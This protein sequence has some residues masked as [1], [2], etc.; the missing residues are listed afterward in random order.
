MWYVVFLVLSSHL[1]FTC[2]VYHDSP[3]QDPDT[4]FLPLRDIQHSHTLPVVSV[5]MGSTYLS[6]IRGVLPR[7]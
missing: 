4:Q 7:S 2:Q 6:S 5:D 3:R 1:T